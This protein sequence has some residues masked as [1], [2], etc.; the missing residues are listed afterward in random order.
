MQAN[1]DCQHLVLADTSGDGTDDQR[2][3]QHAERKADLRQTVLSGCHSHEFFAEIGQNNTE[4]GFIK[5]FRTI[6]RR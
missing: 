5:K 3:Q 1:A 2:T 4:M 6:P